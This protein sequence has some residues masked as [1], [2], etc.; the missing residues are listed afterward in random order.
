VNELYTNLIVQRINF[1]LS[2]AAVAANLEHNGVKGAIR[3][4]LMSE[5]LRPLL[6]PDFGVATGII[7]S[8]D[9]EQ[10]PQ[11]DIII[12]NKRIL[13]PFLT[14]GPALIPIESVVAT[15]EV[16][17]TLTSGELRNAYENV[18]AVRRL[19]LLSGVWKD[20]KTIDVR[21][22]DEHGNL[23]PQSDTVPSGVTSF[24]FAFDSDLTSKT[25]PERF[26][27]QCKDAYAFNAICVVGRGLFGPTEQ[28]FYDYEK[29]QYFSLKDPTHPL[30]NAI[31]EL[32]GADK[33]NSEVLLFITNLH[34]IV[35]KV[36]NTRGYPPLSG[37]VENF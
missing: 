25:E 35:K 16:K 24:L 36:A 31:A 17:S 20:G 23:V 3:E 1:A 29:D 30:T 18:R 10:S 26:A 22:A 2:A 34:R 28:A 8:A 15:I 33:L 32:Q 14:D 11:Q 19:R 37:Y 4:A 9:N 7:I 21:I 12:Y 5:L 27:E 13:P 6:P